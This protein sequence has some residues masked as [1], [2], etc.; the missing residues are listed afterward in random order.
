MPVRAQ[1]PVAG[2]AAVV[3]RGLAHEVDLHRAVDASRGADERVVGVLVERR[4]RV[5]GD[6]ILPTARTH[7]QR[8]AHDHP[9]GGRLPRRDDRVGPRL[10]DPVARDVD[11]ERT[12]P[13]AARA[14]VEQRP[15]TL[16]ESKRGTQSQ[17]TVP[18]GA[19]SAPVWQ[20]ERNAYCATGVNG[21]GAAALCAVAAPRGIT[22]SAR[23]FEA[24]PS[25]LVDAVMLRSFSDG[26]RLVVIRSA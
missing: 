19:T 7:R 16:G 21:D 24:I 13:E 17:S 2:I 8:V 14:A 18:S 9:A 4:S 23:L 26:R 3:E 15:N 10:V 11:P 12:E 5:R 25:V 22:R 6:R 20:L 1:R